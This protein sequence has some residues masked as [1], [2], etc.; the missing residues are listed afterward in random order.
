MFSF[1][2]WRILA[3]LLVLLVGSPS[4]GFAQGQHERDSADK[5]KRCEKAADS[6]QMREL[7]HEARA[8]A[9]GAIAGCSESAGPAL[10]KQWAAPPTDSAA[11]H[12]LFVASAH[13]RDQRIYDAVTMV[14]RNPALA[15]SARLAA[16][17]VLAAYVDPTIEVEPIFLS[18]SADSTTIARLDHPYNQ[19]AGAQPLG[20][21][22]VA[23]VR[24]LCLALA[25]SDPN[26]AMRF[27][28]RYLEYVFSFR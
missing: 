11:L 3:A 17:H 23:G 4:A 19:I 22:A 21:G 28:S 14:A 24:G 1:A 18:P 7:A 16:L 27:A 9:L 13:V 8:R 2:Q 20:A 12:Q 26:P 6:L 5:R 15:I 10:Q 25:Q